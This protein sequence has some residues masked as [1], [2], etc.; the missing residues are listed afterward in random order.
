MMIN[1]DIIV[2]TK[3]DLFWSNVL[4]DMQNIFGSLFVSVCIIKEV[5]HIIFMLNMPVRYFIRPI[6]FAC[7]LHLSSYIDIGLSPMLFQR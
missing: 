4:N 5:N 7:N 3:F 2:F 1:E 6:K